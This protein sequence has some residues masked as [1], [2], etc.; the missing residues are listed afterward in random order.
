MR[1]VW[2]GPVT[3]PSG[4]AAGGRAFLR[5]LSEEGARVRLEPHLWND[6]EAV[7]RAERR[8][9]VEMCEVEMPDVEA[10]VQHT[11]GL[12]FDPYAPGR[13]RVGRTMFETDRIPEDWVARCNQMDEVWVPTEHNRA[14]FAAS[15]VDPGRLAVVPEPFELDRLDRD[16]APLAIPD[17][18][19]TIFLAAFDWTLRKGWDV[20]VAAWAEAFAPG[21]DVTLV[22]KVWS[23]TRGVG[24][25]EIQA[26]IIDALAARIKAAGHSL[27]DEPADQPWGYR[28]FS[29]DDPDGFHLTIIRKL[30]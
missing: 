4:Y 25:P 8:R 7:T 24:T 15:G 29:I 1:I 14:A 2:R 12:H 6:R 5:G 10:S 11:F 13:V 26:D 9:L 30:G 23:T 3:D 27:T 21:D 19:G 22:L 16:A 28:A 17:A 20:L 18:H